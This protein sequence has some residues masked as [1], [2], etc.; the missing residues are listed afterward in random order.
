MTDLDDFMRDNPDAESFSCQENCG[1]VV[2]FPRGDDGMY[3]WI[4]MRKHLLRG[5]KV[6]NFMRKL[7]D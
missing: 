7:H 5:C 1:F 3:A 4:R 2:V 6:D